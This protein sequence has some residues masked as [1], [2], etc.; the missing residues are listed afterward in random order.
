[1]KEEQRIRERRGDMQNWHNLRGEW[2]KQE[3]GG[4]GDK[5]GQQQM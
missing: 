2:I 4:G 3:M 1:M 5:Q